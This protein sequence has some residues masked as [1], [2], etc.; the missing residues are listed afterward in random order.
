M[1]ALR[2]QGLEGEVRV[3]AQ[4]GRF[5]EGAERLI[6]GYGVEVF[7]YLVNNL[8]SHHDASDAF[9]ETCLDVLQGLERFE[10]RASARTWLYVLA[11]NAAHRSR[12][13]PNNRPNLGSVEDLEHLTAIVRSV[14][15]PYLRSEVKDA[16]AHIREAL[17]P[18][19]RTLLTL[20]VDRDMSWNELAMV[21]A[22]DEAETHLPR[23]AARL[24]KRFQ[25]VKEEVRRRAVEA[26]LIER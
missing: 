23:V 8:G 9:Q 11:R 10:W 26:G 4:A 13:S 25:L 20:R 7:G 14:T 22:P 15:S 3:L 5:R 6:E 1:Y 24:R 12:R 21:L 16:F 18:D 19:D 2:V 17:D